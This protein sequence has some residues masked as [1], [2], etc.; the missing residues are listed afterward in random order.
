M[1]LTVG[2][3]GVFLAVTAVGAVLW[4]SPDLTTASVEKPAAQVALSVASALPQSMSTAVA[5]AGSFHPPAFFT[6]YPSFSR[7]N[8]ALSR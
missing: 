7:S 4:Y 8:I 5:V 6:L 3:V 2:G 1:R